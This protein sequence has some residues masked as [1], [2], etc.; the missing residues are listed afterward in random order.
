MSFHS[1]R[2]IVCV[3]LGGGQQLLGITKIQN[4][5]YL[6]CCLTLELMKIL[7]ITDIKDLIIKCFYHSFIC[8]FI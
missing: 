5:A 6:L 1:K 4:T 2:K 8:S 3:N 7:I